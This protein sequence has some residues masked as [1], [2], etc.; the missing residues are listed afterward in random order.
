VVVA[1]GLIGMC[2]TRPKSAPQ[3]PVVMDMQDDAAVVA[4]APASQPKAEEPAVPKEDPREA[5]IRR[6]SAELAKLQAT[7]TPKPAVAAKPHKVKP[8]VARPPKESEG[9]TKPIKTPEVKDDGEIE[10]KRIKRNPRRDE[11]E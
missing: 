7:K 1:A 11:E 8:I 10:L 9:E 6:I 5:E 3:A 2:S 4:A